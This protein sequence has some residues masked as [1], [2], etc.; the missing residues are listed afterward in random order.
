MK[1]LI[2]SDL[3]GSAYYA[4]EL[5]LAVQTEAADKCVLL[6][7]LLYHGPRND[8]PR[9]YDP[10]SVTK[11][12]NDM[13]D[14]LFCVRGNCDADV[15]AMVLDFP[16][17]SD[18]ALILADGYTLFATHGHLYNEE[19]LPPLNKGDV[20]LNGHTHLR[21]AENRKD[22]YFVN[23]G[24]VSIPKDGYSGYTVFENGVFTQKTFDGVAVATLSI[25]AKQ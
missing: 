13:K 17:L 6:G 14:K 22:Y 5:Q 9:E 24:S 7:D 21:I 20:L 8:L 3:H 23:P 15:D 25:K 19:N 18:Y 2:A 1:L 4:K 12:L 11:I 10:K 16:M